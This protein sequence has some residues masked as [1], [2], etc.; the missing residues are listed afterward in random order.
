MS[1]S[2]REESLLRI[3]D[4]ALLLLL[5]FVITF[6][7]M[8]GGLDPESTGTAFLEVLIWFSAFLWF[9]RALSARELAL[10]LPAILL[11]LALFLAA[12]GLAARTAAS[13]GDALRAWSLFR[14]W[15][16]DGALLFLILQH[17]ATRQRRAFLLSLLAAAA[18]VVVLYSLYQRSYGLQYFRQVIAG[19]KAL[20]AQVV[21]GDPAVQESFEFRVQSDRIYGPYG[22]A[23]AL[24]GVLLLFL[25]FV[26]SLALSAWRGRGGGRERRGAWLLLGVATGG[27]IALLYTGSLAGAL[28]AKAAELAAFFALGRAGPARRKGFLVEIALAWVSLSAAGALLAAAGYAW[29]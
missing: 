14:H 18:T 3:L 25:P 11:P 22:Y 21:G 20:V 1:A 4:L 27:T 12:A 2:G 26:W 15:I 6:R 29:G 7:L 17:A 13:G 19:D 5:G 28:A 16:M 9:L 10:R 23:N 8:E 24:A